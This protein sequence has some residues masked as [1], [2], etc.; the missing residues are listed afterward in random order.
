MVIWLIDPFGFGR[1]GFLVLAFSLLWYVGCFLILALRPGRRWI[2]THTTLIGVLYLLLVTGL[3]AAEVTCR[4]IPATEYDPR[5]PHITQLSSEFG[6]SF[7]PGVSDI[8]ENGYRLPVYPPDKAPGRFRIVCIGDGNTCGMCCTW[9]DAWPHQ[10]E[11]LLN[12]D[13]DWSRTHGVTEVVNLGVMMYGPDQSLL[14]LEKRGLSYS[15]D[16][17][18]FQLCVD[19]Y[20]EASCDYYWRM[21]NNT[22]M[23]KPFFVLKEGRLIL[24]RD[25]APPPTDESG[26]AVE[27]PRQILPDLQLSL[28]SFLAHASHEGVAP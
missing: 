17:V 26:K 15:P 24:G 13:A 1:F 10:L 2:A 11:V 12:Q 25:Y 23:Y 9:R 7:R 21:N 20:V 6:W 19:D 22:K 4:S 5:V 8:G 3:V 27:P 28:F 16:L 14:T 18:I